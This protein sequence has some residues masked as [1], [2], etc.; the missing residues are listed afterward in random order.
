VTSYL[1]FVPFRSKAQ[2]RAAF[3]GHIPGFSR[4]RAAEWASETPDVGKLPERVMPRRLRA[5]VGRAELEAAA[6]AGGLRNADLRDTDLSEL[7][8]FHVDLSG[9]DLRG[10]NMRLVDLRDARLVGP[11]YGAQI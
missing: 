4:E 5:N 10:A 2:M 7:D 6:R 3:S 11:T 8:F 9:A 1:R